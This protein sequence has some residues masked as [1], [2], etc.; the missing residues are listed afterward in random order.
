MP[1]FVLP[2]ET[3]AYHPDVAQ[4]LSLQAPTLM[5]ALVRQERRTCRQ[6]CL[7]D[8]TVYCPPAGAGTRKLPVTPLTVNVASTYGVV[9]VTPAG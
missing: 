8:I 2:I 5:L 1:S 6:E 4:T 7:R 3:F 9:D